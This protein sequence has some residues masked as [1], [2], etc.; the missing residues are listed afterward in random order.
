MRRV[1]LVILEALVIALTSRK[2]P[3]V[4][5]NAGN[6]RYNPTQLRLDTCHIYIDTI[7]GLIP[8]DEQSTHCSKR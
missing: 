8:D 6:D 4:Q 5:P 3:C 1:R 7:F 2:M